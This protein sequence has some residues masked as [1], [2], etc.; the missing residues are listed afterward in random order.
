MY[1]VLILH[2]MLKNDYKIKEY[3]ALGGYAIKE[4]NLLEED[5]KKVLRHF[6]LVLI[7]CN[8]VDLCAD[9][10]GQIRQLVQIPIVV[11]S[12]RDDEWEKIRLFQGGIDDYL[13]K[14]Y[15]QGE[16]LARIQAHL[17]RYKRL[18]R[19]F[20]I[21]KVNELEINAFSRRV[22]V[23]GKDVE[24]SLKEFEVLIYLAQHMDRAIT[25]EEIYEAVWKDNL[26]DGVYNTVAVHVKK[27]RAKIEKDID[28]P[29]YI[30]TVWGVGYLFQS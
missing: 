25:K 8:K 27:I 24:L 12:E 7:E 26:A 16:F 13:A 10:V 14:P 20:G 1:N 2:E 5:Y 4:E 19:P 17:E 3:L 18:T 22:T 29:R 6:D 23:E 11:L 9:A 15:W 30:Q 28:N 21:I